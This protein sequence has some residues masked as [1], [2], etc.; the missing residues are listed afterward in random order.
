M[1]L[2]LKGKIAIV[3]GASK[4]IGYGIARTLAAEGARV[5]ITR[6]ARAGAARSAAETHPRR[7]RRRGAADC[8]RL[9]ARRGLHPRRRD[10]RWRAAAASTSW[11]TTTARRRS[12]RSLTFD[13]TAW[14]K[15]VEQNLMYVVR[16]ARGVRAAS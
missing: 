10:R 9:P 11:S 7:D 8:R 15:A 3:G 2:E 13:D 16:M 5:A 12:A 1:D 6:A 14:A 4:G